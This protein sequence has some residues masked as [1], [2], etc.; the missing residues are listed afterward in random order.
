MKKRILTVVTNASQLDSKR[1]TGLWLS[2]LVDF[3]HFF[4]EK[5]FV[6]DIMSPEGGGVPL[7]EL[8]LTPIALTGASKDYYEDPEFMDKLN[9]SLAPMS[10]KEEDYDCIYFAGGHGTMIDFLD[11]IKIQEMVKNIYETGGVVA[12]VCHGPVALLNV[13][14]SN[15]KFLLD[16]IKATGFSDVEE[17]L[18]GAKDNIPYSL[19][20]E[21]KNRGADYHK[22]LIPMTSHV[23]VSGNLVTGQNPASAEK[24][25]EEV[26]ELL[27]RIPLI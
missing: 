26:Y 25:A 27:Q 17:T 22:A 24:V 9:N 21:M 12:A 18:V 19:E 16:G 15:G 13:K 4:K 20:E 6:V 14:L 11:S 23:E 1:D 8:S 3:Y 5:G 7:D 2:E 10:V